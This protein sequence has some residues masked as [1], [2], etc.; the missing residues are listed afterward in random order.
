MGGCDERRRRRRWSGGK[1]KE[2]GMKV[3]KVFGE[4]RMEHWRDTSAHDCIAG[5]VV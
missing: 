4:I 2:G 1:W 3:E 5:D